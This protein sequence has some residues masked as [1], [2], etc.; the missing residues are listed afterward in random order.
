MRL[1]Q[2]TERLSSMAENKTAVLQ[3]SIDQ[4]SNAAAA[5]AR[6]AAAAVSAAGTESKD[7][8]WG[9]RSSM[10]INRGA[11][12]GGGSSRGSAEHQRFTRK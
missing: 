3:E 8:F 12:D 2:E 5:A 11:R 7:E 1:S 4:L 10:T 6:A 9:G